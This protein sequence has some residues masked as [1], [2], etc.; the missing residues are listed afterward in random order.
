MSIFIV[1]PDTSKAGKIRFFDALVDFRAEEL[2][3]WEGPPVQFLI[4]GVEERHLFANACGT[5]DRPV[6]IENAPR[7]RPS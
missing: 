4:G 2:R 1:F 3:S 7:A 5:D 6:P